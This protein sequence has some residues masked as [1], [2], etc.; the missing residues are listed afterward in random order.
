[1]KELSYQEHNVPDEYM[2]KWQKTVNIMARI[3]EVPAGLIMRVLPTQIEVLVSSQ[4]GGNPYKPDEKADLNTGLYCETVMKTQKQ[5]HIPNALCDE[6][7]KDNPDVK[8]DMTMYLGIPLMWSE[9]QVFGTICV[10]DNKTRHFSDIYQSLLWEF[11]EV[12]ESDFK[13]IL[14]KKELAAR[15]QEL[16]MFN[17]TMVAREMRIIELKKEVNSLCTKLDRNPVYPQIW[18]QE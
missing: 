14:H 18:E 11:K 5:L 7:W 16:E 4:T 2:A 8:L 10:L 1:M 13:V 17:K 6:H 9:N 12:I 15:N 3:F